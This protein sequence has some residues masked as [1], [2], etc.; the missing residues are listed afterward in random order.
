MEIIHFMGILTCELKRGKKK[1][2]HAY[3][4]IFVA[5]IKLQN[6]I[7]DNVWEKKTKQVQLDTGDM[8]Y[9]Q[10]KQNITLLIHVRICPVSSSKSRLEHCIFISTNTCREKYRCR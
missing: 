8:T 7:L 10:S 6:I 2:A 1:N 5:H 9:L 4:S 3:R